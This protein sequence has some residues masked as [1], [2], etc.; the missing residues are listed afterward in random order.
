V[1]YCG[2]YIPDI[3]VQLSDLRLVWLRNRWVLFVIGLTYAGI[4]ARFVAL[5]MFA[6][7]A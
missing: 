4:I 1:A 3:L 7:A 5:R 6:N 2:A